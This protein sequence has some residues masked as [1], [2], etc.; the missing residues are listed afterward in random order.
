MEAANTCANFFKFAFFI[1][2]FQI[3]FINA[4]GT[5]YVTYNSVVKLLNVDYNVRLHSHDIQYGSGSGQ[6]SV[7][8]IEAKEDGNSY[9]LV[10]GPTGKQSIRG[11]PIK[12]GDVI[13]FEHTTTK[14]NL[15]SHHVSSP[16][17]GRQEVSAYGN[18]GEGDTGDHWTVVCPGTHWE[19][20]ETIMFK[21]IDTNA[22]LA[23]TGRTYGSPISGQNEVVGEYSTNSYSKWQVMEGLFIHPNDFISQHNKHI[24]L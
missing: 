3:S 12:C 23:V 21:H 18:Q 20:D 11:K 15:H 24:E 2:F 17:S 7:T 5:T 16:L 1:L 9:W 10:K 13:R 14:K 22:Y 8:A 4:K 19:R 6:Q